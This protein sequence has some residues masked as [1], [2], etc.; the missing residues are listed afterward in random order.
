[1]S[2]RIPSVK[3]KASFDAP[4]E[5]NKGEYEVTN[6]MVTGAVSKNSHFSHAIENS[7]QSFHQNQLRREMVM[8]RNVQGL[9][10]PMRL[11]MELKAAE[12]VGRHPF[13]PSSGLMRDVLLGRDEE[14]GFED[15]LNCSEFKEEMGQP[16]AIV[17]K[18]LG[19]F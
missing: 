2:F 15:V 17:E 10:A 1:M 19:F 7:E 14:I 3:S 6:P 18:K 9:H 12:R 16:H 8:L 11:A 4:F 13:M 5:V